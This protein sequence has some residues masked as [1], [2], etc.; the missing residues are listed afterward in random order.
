MRSSARAASIAAVLTLASALSV[1]TS[2]TTLQQ[3]IKLVSTTRKQSTALVSWG[4]DAELWEKVENKRNLVKLVNRGEEDRGRARIEKLRALLVTAE[5]TEFVGV[6]SPTAVDLSDQ[7]EV[8]MD[9]IQETLATEPIAGE[10]MEVACPSALP[11]DRTVRVSLPDLREFDVVVP[12]G[13]AA[14]E[15]FLVGP[16][17]SA[18]EPSEA[19]KAT[20]LTTAGTVELTTEMTDLTVE[21]QRAAAAAAAEREA[22]W[23][24]RL[25][26]LPRATMVAE[27]AAAAKGLL[28]VVGG[29]DMQIAAADARRAAVAAKRAES[30]ATMAAALASV[31]A[32]IAEIEASAAR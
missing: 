31:E 16:F 21:E 1:P 20:E 27:A 9:I 13:V 17:P 15:V 3:P 6:V 26:A 24:R 5:G 23:K 28:A 22:T 29:E 18:T 19:A 4:M 12:E 14:G 10:V 2:P 25:A 30:G 7:A 11:A 8:P 32:R